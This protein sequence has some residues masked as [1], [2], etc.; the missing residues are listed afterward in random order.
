MRYGRAVKNVSKEQLPHAMRVNVDSGLAEPWG[1][2][3]C[4][5]GAGIK[6]RSENP[7]NHDPEHRDKLAQLLKEPLPFAEFLEGY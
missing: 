6:C 7:A 5:G 2:P 4:I 1:V 3:R